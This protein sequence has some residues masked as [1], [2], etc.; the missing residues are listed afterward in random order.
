MKMT[1]KPRG[2]RENLE[3]ESVARV[4]YRAGIARGFLGELQL[5]EI[6]SAAEDLLWQV[7]QGVNT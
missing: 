3:H 1:L 2:T 4:K 5:L 6:V 7:S